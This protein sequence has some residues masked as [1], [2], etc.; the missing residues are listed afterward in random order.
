MATLAFGAAGAALGSWMAPA[1]WSSLGASIGWSVGVFAG[2]RLFGP[3]F[4]APPIQGPRLADL[5]VQ[6]SLY[7]GMVPRVYG[8]MRIAGNVVWS[9]DIVETATTAVVS[10]GGGGGGKGGGGGGG[11]T[12][13]TQTT[14][15]YSVNLVIAVCEGSIT[16]IRKIWADGKLIYNLAA[17]A[18]VDTMVASNQQVPHIRIY[19]GTE[20]QTA[21]ALMEA[22]EGAGNVPGYRGTAHV[23]LED[24]QL[25]DYGNRI[26]NFEFE[27]VANGTSEAMTVAEYY[28]TGLGVGIMGSGT[29]LLRDGYLIHP[30][31]A[32]EYVTNVYS[33]VL[34]RYVTEAYGNIIGRTR[35]KNALVSNATNLWFIDPDGPITTYTLSGAA[36]VGQNGGA[37]QRSVARIYAVGDSTTPARFYV[38]DLVGSTATCTLVAAVKMSAIDRYSAGNITGRIYGLGSS[39]Y[40]GGSF[41]FLGYY[42]E[43]SGG[44]VQIRNDIVIRA[45]CVT[46]SG[47]LWA[48]QGGANNS[49]KLLNLDPDDGSTLATVLL[50]GVSATASVSGGSIFEGFDGVLSVATNLT[51]GSDFGVLRVDPVSE[52]V[53]AS[54][55]DIASV[56]A[57][58]FGITDD[59]I[60]VTSRVGN[61]DAVGL[62]ERGIRITATAPTV[63]SVVT[64][65]CGLVGLSAADINI[66]ALTETVDGYVI[67]NRG[68]ARGMIE[69]LMV[70]YFFDAVE[71]DNKVKFVARGGASAVTIPEAD[72]AA[73]A[74]EIEAT[75]DA[76][77]LT[78]RQEVELPVEVNVVY[79]NKANGYQFG[80]Q[81]SRRLITSAKDAQT[82]QLPIALS[83]DKARQIADAVMY[84]AWCGR[85]TLEFQTAREY[86]KYE[87]TDVVSV[88]KGAATLI[89]RLT[90]KD[91]GANGV[92][93]WQAALE[94]SSTYTQTISGVGSDLTDQT[95]GINGPTLL[96][97]MDIPLLRD[98]DDDAGFYGAVAGYAASW[99]GAVLYSSKD[100]GATWDAIFGGTFLTAAAIGVA[101]TALGDF[102]RPGVFDEG[103]SVDVQLIAGSLA[104]ATRA[105]V[106][107][108]ANVCLLGSEILQFRTA[109][110][111][112]TSQYRLTGLLRGRKG[113]EW[114]TASHAVGDRFVLL[115]STTVKRI[116][117]STADLNVE[118]QYKPISIGNTISQTGTKFFTDTGIGL[119]PLSPGQLGGGRNASGDIIVKWARRTR[120]EA[121]WR[122]NV[123][124]PLGEASESYSVDVMS[125]S[126]VLRT[127]TRAT[128]TV[129]YTAAQQTTDWGS[130]QSSVVFKVYQVSAAFGRGYAGQV[131]V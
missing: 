101:Q 99:R 123:D 1:G 34:V 89:V 126:T 110:L 55:G 90:R 57:A 91:E 84:S 54:T 22:A 68:P 69:P 50:T 125:G 35:E 87:P 128:P 17:D 2:G 56:A 21:D 19:T 5:K 78:R 80:Q 86:L 7:G 82:I 29:T 77:V 96:E 14:Y 6:V 23:V 61:T 119:K 103:G 94:D 28:D 51:S 71:S 31:G 30:G 67:A 120:Y 74:D 79:P 13:Q 48:L 107:D 26:P 129:T 124:A 111:I 109:T 122:D 60:I 106:L 15:S 131:T 11:A 39:A 27:V 59:D 92:I 9:S 62:I 88:V 46:R 105:Q 76:A 93:R 85:E 44:Y 36:S 41:T 33:K 25:A 114:A 24:F 72:L 3:N 108:N 45:L 40:F 53:L 18:S 63:G 16:G 127:L 8:S 10:T 104:S 117:Q 95:V 64:S 38:V 115:S 43:A 130:P 42:N 52:T 75:P 4:E 47:E 112:G 97:C 116:A 102:T 49:H 12:T 98:A 58:V 83:D 37:W 113:T 70:A 100:Q 65:I 66:A 73:R 121:P 81:A 20:T 118:R 32:G